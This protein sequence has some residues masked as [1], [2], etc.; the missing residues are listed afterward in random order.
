MSSYFSPDLRPRT[1]TS[2][3]PEKGWTRRNN[4]LG[5]YNRPKSLK[6]SSMVDRNDANKQ[7]LSIFQSSALQLQPAEQKRN[8]ASEPRLS[9]EAGALLAARGILRR[10]MYN[11]W[12]DSERAARAG[13]RY[14]LSYDNSRVMAIEK[15]QQTIEP[16]LPVTGQ[17]SSEVRG[18]GLPQKTENRAFVLTSATTRNGLSDNN[19]DYNT[20]INGDDDNGQKTT[21]NAK[22]SSVPTI[23]KKTS[24]A[25]AGDK[26]EVNAERKRKPEVS[27]TS[28]DPKGNGRRSSSFGRSLAKPRPSISQPNASSRWATTVKLEQPGSYQK[29]PSLPFTRTAKSGIGKQEVTSNDTK[30]I[31]NVADQVSEAKAAGQDSSATAAGGDGDAAMMEDTGPSPVESDIEEGDVL[32]EEEEDDAG[33]EI[34]QRLIRVLSGYLDDLP[35]IARKVVRIFTSSTFTGILLH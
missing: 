27:G 3:A 14:V 35:P 32:M 12:V 7:E 24:F 28:G 17:S 19:N 20:C 22:K 6:P 5:A 34:D 4:M 18:G 13:S 16:T 2:S 29:P 1:R 21:V 30:P 25:E 10:R 15:Q 26:P 33:K 23:K 11:N 31:G 8:A 9:K